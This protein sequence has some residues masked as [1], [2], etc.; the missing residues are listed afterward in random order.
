MFYEL[1]SCD[2]GNLWAQ[3]AE[4]KVD[5]GKKLIREEIREK[6]IVKKNVKEE[7]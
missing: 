3:A 6:V 1:S 4:S 7:N 2:E 5:Y